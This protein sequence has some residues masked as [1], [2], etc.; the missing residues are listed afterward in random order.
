MSTSALAVKPV[1]A[2]RRGGPVWAA[3]LA[4]VL[5][6]SSV[7]LAAGAMAILVRY[8]LGGPFDLEPYGK[9]VPMVLLHPLSLAMAG[10]YP[11]RGLNPVAELRGLCQA[12]TFTFLCLAAITFFQRD[13]AAY[14]R[15]SLPL[16]WM[17]T[18]VLS[19][20]L[21]QAARGLLAKVG[22]SGARAVIIGAGEAGQNLA[23]ALAGRPSLGFEVAALLDDGA[24]G[25]ARGQH[26]IAGGLDLAPSFA[27]EG[28]ATYAILALPEAS[29]SELTVLIERY[30]WL[31]RHVLVLPGLFG[32]TSLGAGTRD[33]AGVLGVEV[34]H[35][36]MC[37]APRVFKRV[38][39]LVL[40]LC[41][42]LA[43]LPVA[44]VICMSIRLTSAGPIFYASQRVGEG[45][46]RF[47]A[48]KFRTM[49]PGA[50][51][52]LRQ[53]LERHPELRDE[54]ERESKIRHDP[55]VTWI[56]RWLRRTSLDE[57]PQL[58]NVIRGE[59]SLVGPRPILPH[60]VA[61]YG[62]CY[63]LYERT[64]PGLTGLWQVSGRNNTTYAQRLGYVQY[65]VR[66][67][68]VWLDLYILCRTVK[69]VLTGE[70]A[71]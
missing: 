35:L 60:E 56:G 66:N 37:P 2:A 43:L 27:R 22:F 11:A 70:G 19:P 10:M 31:Y 17:L 25:R 18:V 64:R 5:L 14:S 26:P 12:S 61:R 65:Y 51:E 59:M 38:C 40:A 29:G 42:G 49:V 9:F 15:V 44:G 69:V 63:P 67:W 30:L 41:G 57:L 54:Y 16:A 24:P 34:R 7:V 36:L 62:A 23:Q 50:T 6:D 4:L 13:A 68:S 20:W 53:Y 46:R 3:D 52:V 33:V 47:S 32:I 8:W 28:G 21:R 39:D 1:Q 55:R 58:W 71:Y 48:W 45:G